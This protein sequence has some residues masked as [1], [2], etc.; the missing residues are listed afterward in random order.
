MVIGR[1]APT[2]ANYQDTIP[3]SDVINKHI[4]SLCGRVVNKSAS[5]GKACLNPLMWDKIVVK[6]S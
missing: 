4:S 2:K 6:L 5:K 3:K 1:M